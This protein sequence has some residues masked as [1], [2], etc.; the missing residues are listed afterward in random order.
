MAI[1]YKLYCVKFGDLLPSRYS[2]MAQK[3]KVKRQDHSITPACTSHEHMLK[4]FE[5][6]VTTS[7]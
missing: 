7:V 5:R 4:K 6:D 2:N 1:A 3:A